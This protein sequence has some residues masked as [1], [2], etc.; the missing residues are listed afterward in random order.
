VGYFRKQ[1]FR[2]WWPV[3]LAELAVLQ[4]KA[5]ERLG[6]AHKGLRPGTLTT[7]AAI[8]YAGTTPPRVAIPAIDLTLDDDPNLLWSMAYALF[9]KDIPRREA[10]KERW[11][12]FLDDLV[13]REK[14]NQDGIPVALDGIAE[15]VKQVNRFIKYHQADNVDTITGKLQ[16]LYD[17]N[18]IFAKDT[19]YKPPEPE[20]YSDW[21]TKVIKLVGELRT[22]VDAVFDQTSNGTT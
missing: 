7:I 19:A 6:Y 1:E 15:L 18:L 4:S 17:I 11:D 13:P 22:K 20:Q 5:L 8:G 21:R 3:N 16:N 9:W 2:Y 14:F 10:L 12:E